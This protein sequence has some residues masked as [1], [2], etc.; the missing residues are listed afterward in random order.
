MNPEDRRRGDA[1]VIRLRLDEACACFE[2]EDLARV[3]RIAVAFGRYRTVRRLGALAGEPYRRWLCERALP[4]VPI[5][6]DATAGF[7]VDEAMI[8]EIAGELGEPVPALLAATVRLMLARGS[9]HI[10]KL[11]V[12]ARLSGDETLVRQLQPAFDAR[13][14]FPRRDLPHAVGP[15][16]A[17][18]QVG[19]DDD[20]NPKSAHL[21]AGADVIVKEHLR[22]HLDPS[23]ID[24]TS[25]E[26]ELL[27]AID[28]PRVVRLLRVDTV[29]HHELLV[30][31]RAPGRALDGAQLPR[32]QA[33]RIGAQLAEL[34]AWLHARRILYLDVKPA[35]VLWDGRDV[36]LCDLGM[37][38]GG[39]A[40]VTSVLSTLE[41]V[42]PEMAR[43]FEATERA[44]VFQLGILLH[45]LLTGRH[46]FSDG[47]GVE[48]AVANL[49]DEP[50]LEALPE[51]LGPMLRRC[52]EERPS[53]AQVAERL[54]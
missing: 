6:G 16:L 31:A 27:E 40:R 10:A 26:R 2:G 13:A 43:G 18:V 54:A 37:A 17:V 15:G 29:A 36:T 22:L 38:R 19:D 20:Y 32:E 5:G 41:Y 50:R 52:P 9:R 28:H 49:R 4:Q 30:L 53:A 8:A 24:G 39:Q 48:V 14:A 33:L 45:Q 46:P 21:F 44:D 23:R 12:L 47:E 25:E 3:G 35:N 42:P 51:L 34:L 11:Y 1:L 7:C